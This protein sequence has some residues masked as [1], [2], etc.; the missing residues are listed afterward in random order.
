MYNYTYDYH[1]YGYK[2]TYVA[3]WYI[4]KYTLMT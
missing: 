2:L 3:I 1:M 4:Y